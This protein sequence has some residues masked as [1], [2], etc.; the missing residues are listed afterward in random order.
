MSTNT[1]STSDRFEA[2][3]LTSSLAKEEDVGKVE[4]ASPLVATLPNVATIARLANEFFAALPGASVP[5]ASP[6]EVDL[7]VPS[8]SLSRTSVPD[9]SREMFSFPGVPN[10]G[11]P[12]SGVP[13]SGVPNSS[14]VPG[15]PQMPPNVP[16]GA[17]N[18]ADFQAIAASLAGVMALVPQVP[19]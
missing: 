18:E 9:Y 3:S 13:N 15:L 10:S 2:G 12:N 11:V 5:V 4:S 17:L 14:S 16:T 1:T 6:N 8:V 7:R 19:T